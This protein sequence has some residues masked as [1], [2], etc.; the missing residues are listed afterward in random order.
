MPTKDELQQRVDELEAENAKLREQ[1]AAAPAVVNYK[2]TRPFLSEGERQDL[3]QYGV[4]NSPFTGEQIT[5]SGEGV[6]PKTAT[7]RRADERAADTRRD[8]AD[9]PGLDHVPAEIVTTTDPG[10]TPE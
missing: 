6:E 3:Q 5:A 9:V 10:S 8:R 2:P 7:A 4:T 1:G